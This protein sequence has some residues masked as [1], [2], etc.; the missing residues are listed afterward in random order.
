MIIVWNI[1]EYN[2]DDDDDKYRKNDVLGEKFMVP[3]YE[4]D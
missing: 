2:D 3:L 4:K 1:H